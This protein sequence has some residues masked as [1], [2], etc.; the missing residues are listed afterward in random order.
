MLQKLENPTMIFTQDWVFHT[1]QGEGRYLGTPSIFI[2]LSSCNLRCRW[3]NTDG[4]TTFCDTPYSSFAPE[5]FSFSL[6]ETIEKLEEFDCSHVVITGGEP[7]YQENVRELI[8]QLVQR[9]YF[10]TVETNGTIFDE[11]SFPSFISIAPKLVSSGHENS[12][13]HIANI[14]SWINHCPQSY[15]LKFVYHNLN[16]L[17]EIESIV[18]QTNAESRNV[19]LMPM[20]S[21]FNLLEKNAPKVLEICKQKKWNYSDRL[22]LR[23]WKGLRGH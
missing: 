16:D 23:L 22:H 14:K 3:R 7:F 9:N 18:E 12:A 21:D 8:N 20:A 2:R 11:L 17:E 15:Q 19:Y 6:L 5:K 1:I 13:Q 4:S 10:V